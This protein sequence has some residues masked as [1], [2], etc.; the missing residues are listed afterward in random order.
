LIQRDPTIP[1]FQ[2]LPGRY[3]PPQPDKYPLNRLATP[4]IGLILR[5]VA[6]CLIIAAIW[7]S[8]VHYTGPTSTLEAFM[9]ASLVADDGHT[10]YS[11][12]CPE[13]QAKVTQSQVQAYLD[14]FKVD[15]ALANASIGALTYTMVDENFFREAHVRVSGDAT[16][17]D[18]AKNVVAFDDPTKNLLT[19]QSAGIGWCLTDGNLTISAS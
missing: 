19:L 7:G 10:A 17:D 16:V 2:P 5:V 6:G 18:R 8:Y 3:R 15:P 11:F 13:A 4:R 12:L 9:Q 1:Y 14:T